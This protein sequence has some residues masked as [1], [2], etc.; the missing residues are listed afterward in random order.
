MRTC[1][2]A[3]ANG[4][5]LLMFP[6]LGCYWARRASGPE[7]FLKDVAANEVQHRIWR[8]FIKASN[9][10]TRWT[11]FHFSPAIAGRSMAGNGREIFIVSYR[12]F[13]A[14]AL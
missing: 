4:Q 6:D 14:L 2:L 7:Q 8:R 12:G 1:T 13:G 5:Y 9:K 10:L 11:N 3:E